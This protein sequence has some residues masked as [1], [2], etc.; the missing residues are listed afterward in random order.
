[1]T[2]AKQALATLGRRLYQAGLRWWNSRHANEAAALA[3][4]SLFSLIPILVLTL[5][6]AT[7]LVGKDTAA[8]KLIEQTTEVTGLGSVDFLNLALR[9]D[10]QWFES[11]Y[12]SPIIGLMVLAFSATK[13][14]HELRITLSKIFGN[15]RAPKKQRSMAVAILISRGVS[16]LAIIVLGCT[17]AISVV[18][19][20]IVV[21]LCQFFEDGHNVYIAKI[22]RYLSSATSFLSLC[23]LGTL[24]LRLLP[25]N[26]PK[27]KEAFMGGILCSS[28]LFILKFG[29]FIFLKHSSTTSMFGGAVT[30]VVLLIWIYFAMQLVLYSAEFTAIITRERESNKQA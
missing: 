18:G 15:E 5:L 28:L 12:V 30:L 8:S 26:P 17:I 23:F 4:Y 9:Y 27:L 29:L 19:E 24:I 7:T 20:S 2:A 16:V 10:F 3:F 14:I 25:Q 6:V 13:V 1:M 11:N 21:S 22:I